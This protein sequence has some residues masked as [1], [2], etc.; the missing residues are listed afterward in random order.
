MTTKAEILKAIRNKCLECS[1]GQPGEVRIC[2]LT[3]CDLWPLRF[4][5]D[6][7]PS[8]GRGFAKSHVYTGDFEDG[9]AVS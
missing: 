1:C 9:E 2:H 6:P 4:G 5:R 7:I 8:R 3:T